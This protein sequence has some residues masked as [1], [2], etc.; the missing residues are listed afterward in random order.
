MDSNYPHT[1]PQIKQAIFSCIV[2]D[3][4]TPEDKLLNDFLLDTLN[5]CEKAF[6]QYSISKIKWSSLF[7][8]N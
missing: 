5:A 2:S 8:T 6:G 7:S 3:F 1:P 4:K